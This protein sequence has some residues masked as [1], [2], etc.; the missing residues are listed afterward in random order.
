[1]IRLKKTSEIDTIRL[2]NNI[3]EGTRLV[4]FQIMNNGNI[5][6]IFER[7]LDKDNETR[8]IVKIHNRLGIQRQCSFTA[9]DSRLKKV[10]LNF[11]ELY[12]F[13]SGIDEEDIS[14]NRVE[15]ETKENIVELQRGRMS[16]IA[17]VSGDDFIISYE[18]GR[19]IRYEKGNVDIIKKEGT[20]GILS[21][22]FNRRYLIYDG[23]GIINPVDERRLGNIQDG[24][25]KAFLVARGERALLVFEDNHIAEY[26]KHGDI[27]EKTGETDEL[28]Y[29]DC[30]MMKDTVAAIKDGIIY[31]YKMM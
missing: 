7:K 5:A 11:N 14:F 23:E 21:L 27:F 25:I 2:E 6:M 30:V 28:A 22:D 1:M 26:D 19:I 18:D 17:G 16:Q 9:V 15:P 12:A 31:V 3:G 10:F 24:D 4:S 8:C 29:D 20:K 13:M